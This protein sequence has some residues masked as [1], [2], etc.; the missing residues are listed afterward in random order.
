MKKANLDE[1]QLQ[2]RNQ[3]GRQ[4]FYLLAFL[5]L[6]DMG[7]NNYGIHWLA[8]PLSNYFIFLVGVGSYLVRIIWNGSYVG[9]G[10]GSLTSA[11]RSLVGALIAILVAVCVITLALSNSPVESSVRNTAAP[12]LIIFAAV[13]AVILGGVR[14][15]RR[16]AEQDEA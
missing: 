14:W 16:R 12:L 6:A 5:L 3:A 2:K 9:P 15:I 7:L 8:Y 1:W 10:S 13:T 4:T 11:S